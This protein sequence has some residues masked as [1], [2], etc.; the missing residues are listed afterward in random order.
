MEQQFLEAEKSTKAKIFIDNRESEAFDGLFRSYN[1]D[2]ERKQLE[3]GDFVCSDRCI[4]ERKTRDDFEASII[5][6]RLFRQ[7]PNLTANYMRVVII[8][9]GEVNAERIRKE[10]LLGAYATLITDFGVGLFFTR[11]VE[12]TAELVYAIAKHEQLAEKRP[13][14]LFAKRKTHTISQT[15]RAIVETFPMIGPKHAKALLEHFGNIENMINASEQE[16]KEVE[17]MGEKRAKAM[18]NIINEKYDS[19]ED[20]YDVF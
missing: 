19:E 17:G 7:L 9:E 6:G 14:R 13:N 5:D 8:V 4:V 20:M 2:V 12:K 10:A 3:V 1:A 18:R 11:N 15:Q 16:L